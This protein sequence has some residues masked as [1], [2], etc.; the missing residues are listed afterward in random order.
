MNSEFASLA[1]VVGSDSKVIAAVGKPT[2]INV[3]F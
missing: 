2:G 1:D 3:N